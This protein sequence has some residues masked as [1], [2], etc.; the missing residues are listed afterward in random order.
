[1]ARV[2]VTNGANGAWLGSARVAP[3]MAPVSEAI[4]FE[5]IK[6]RSIV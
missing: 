1:M 4:T 5:S 6:I 2:K 3:V